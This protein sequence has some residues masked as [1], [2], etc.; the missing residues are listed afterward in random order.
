M[1]EPIRIRDL[2]ENLII[3]SGCTPGEEMEIQ[4]TGIRSGEKL[5]EELFYR[6]AE[7][8]A[9]PFRGIHI[10]RCAV[11]CEGLIELVE[12]TEERINAIEEDELIGIMDS[13]IRNSM[14]VSPSSILSDEKSRKSSPIEA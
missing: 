2:A 6:N 8:S 4:Y 3:L 9:S 14:P 1:G 12:N 7:I 13:I 10:E 11:S 5:R